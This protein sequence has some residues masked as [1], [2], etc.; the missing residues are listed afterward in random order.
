MHTRR[1]VKT[2]EL[3]EEMSSW[4]TRVRRVRPVP[5]LLTGLSSEVF[6]ASLLTV[7][8]ITPHDAAAAAKCYARKLL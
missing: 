5:R 2:D 6:V 7:L 4:T 3:D 1:A 8:I